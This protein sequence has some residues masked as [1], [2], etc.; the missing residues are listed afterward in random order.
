[1]GLGEGGDLVELAAHLDLDVLL[2]IENLSARDL[3][4]RLALHRR[5]KKVGG[6]GVN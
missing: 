5:R 1:M 2:A 4:D 3:D 6:E